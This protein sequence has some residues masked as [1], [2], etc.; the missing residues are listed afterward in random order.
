MYICLYVYMYI[1]IHICIYIYTYIYTGTEDTQGCR[2]STS[3]ALEAEEDGVRVANAVREAL[4]VT[5]SA[6]HA[7]IQM[8]Q[9][10]LQVLRGS[11]IGFCHGQLLLRMRVLLLR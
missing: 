11:Q 5:G 7:G 6:E 8:L 9:A 3:G 4:N 2:T 10:K 1:C